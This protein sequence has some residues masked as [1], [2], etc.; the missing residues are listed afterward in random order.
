MLKNGWDNQYHVDVIRHALTKN[1][2]GKFPEV[3]D[4]VDRAFSDAVAEH[5]TSDGE[6]RG[7]D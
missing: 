6:R 2:G 1:I 4:E 7:L 3:I 5:M